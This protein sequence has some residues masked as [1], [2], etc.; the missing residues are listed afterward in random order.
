MATKYFLFIKINSKTES[1]SSEDI[2]L[3]IQLTENRLFLIYPLALTRKKNLR[4]FCSLIPCG[5]CRCFLYHWEQISMIKF[6][7]MHNLQG[8]YKLSHYSLHS[9]AFATLQDS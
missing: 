7:N 3:Y 6:I 8:N 1:A 9:L 4:M 5:L 2:V